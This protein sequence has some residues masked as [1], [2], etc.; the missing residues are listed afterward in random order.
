MNLSQKEYLIFPIRYFLVT[1]GLFTIVVSFSVDMIGLGNP[2]FGNIQSILFVAGVLLCV[3]GVLKDY[4]SFF[5]NRARFIG[6]IYLT[7]ILYVGLSFR[8]YTKPHH[9]ILLGFDQFHFIDFLINWIGFI[10]LAYLLM[11]GFGNGLKARKAH[12]IKWAFIA[13]GFGALVSFF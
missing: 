2:G 4:F 6:T 9:N 12:I 10:P 8:S 13:T 7:F 1:F 3:V 11:V 5:I